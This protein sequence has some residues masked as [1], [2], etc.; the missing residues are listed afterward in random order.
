MRREGEDRRLWQPTSAN[1]K[2]SEI[3][4]SAR[5]RE[6]LLTRSY[7]MMMNV[8]NEKGKWPYHDETNEEK[9]NRKMFL[10]SSTTKLLQVP[11][12]PW[13]V[14]MNATPYSCLFVLLEM[15]KANIFYNFLL[16]FSIH[17]CCL[18][19]L[20]SSINMVHFSINYECQIFSLPGTISNHPNRSEINSTN[21][22]SYIYKYLRAFSWPTIRYCDSYS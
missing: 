15:F 22:W 13:N 4:E 6:H 20:I 3:I 8:T 18:F 1:V 9:E 10:Y 19:N 7:R 21:N 12:T 5:K 16:S 11:K 2:F 14:W 17:Y